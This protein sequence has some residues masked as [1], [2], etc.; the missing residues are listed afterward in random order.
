MSGRILQQLKLMEGFV[1]ETGEKG[2]EVINTESDKTVNESRS[3]V[4]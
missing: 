1:R 4:F 3:G 2:V